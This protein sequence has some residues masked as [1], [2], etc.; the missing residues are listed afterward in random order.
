[1]NQQDTGTR[2]VLV[3]LGPIG[4]RLAR[5]VLSR[6][7]LDV[8]GA[9]DLNPALAGRDLGE[10]A[11]SQP[12]TGVQVVSGIDALPA[13]PGVAILSTTSRLGS[14]TPQVE[15]LAGQGWNVL[16]TCEELSYPASVDEQ[17]A[18]RIDDAARTAGISVLGAGINPGFLLDTLVLSLRYA[19]ATV[20]AVRVQR[21]V[22]TNARRKPLQ[23]KAGVGLTKD[24][25]E[26][27]ARTGDVGHVGLRQS[28]YLL[29]SGLGWHLTGYTETIEPVIAD[30]DITTGLGIVEAGG[31]IG[32]HQHAVATAAGRPVIDYDLWMY[33]GSESTD[34]IVIEGEPTISQIVQGGVNGDIG[35]EAVVANLITEVA[36][37]PPGLLTMARLTS[38]A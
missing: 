34:R 14:I 8:V 28:A 37:A 20:E 5:R 10:L 25:F 4:L 18:Q 7:D 16:S 3:G 11:G 13:G 26:R 24:E 1:M 30:S 2:V 22:D 33:A 32:Q 27:R 31:V 38:L 9:A 12:G 36:A 17:L 15:A 19:C 35:T 29:A 23:A 21:I 6:A